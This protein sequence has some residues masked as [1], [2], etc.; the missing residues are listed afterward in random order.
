MSLRRIEAE[1]LAPIDEVRPLLH[2]AHEL[3]NF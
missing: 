2:E 3:D 1:K